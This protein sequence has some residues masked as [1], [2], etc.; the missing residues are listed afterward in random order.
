MRDPGSNARHV[1]DA[2]KT[3]DADW[4]QPRSRGGFSVRN[5]HKCG[6]GDHIE[7]YS[8]SIAVDANDTDPNDIDASVIATEEL[9]KVP[10]AVN[11]AGPKKQSPTQGK[12]VGPE[13]A[14]IKKNTRPRLGKLA[15][16]SD[17]KLLPD[18]GDGEGHL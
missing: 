11:R 10:K 16:H 2:V 18:G 3:L 13:A 17:T 6:A 14:G 5:R 15:K 8:K 7:H 1:I 4:Q 12:L 9:A